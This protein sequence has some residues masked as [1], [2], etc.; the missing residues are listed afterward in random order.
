M[1]LSTNLDQSSTITACTLFSLDSFCFFFSSLSLQKS[2][3]TS[4]TVSYSI[5]LMAQKTNLYAFIQIF[6][7]V[8]MIQFKHH[9]HFW[10]SQSFKSHFSIKFEDPHFIQGNKR[11][12]VECY[13]IAAR[14]CSFQWNLCYLMMRICFLYLHRM[15]RLLCE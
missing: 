5:D 1:S 15:K 14:L 7:N 2:H 8:T 12:A 6:A 11:F 3:S 9:F 4:L 10:R 13:G